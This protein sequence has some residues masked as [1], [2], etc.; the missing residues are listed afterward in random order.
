MK[1]GDHSATI[2][3]PADAN[4]RSASS[5]GKFP[6]VVAPPLPAP[7][8]GGKK[9]LAIFDFIFRICAAVAALAAAAAMSNGQETLPFFTQFFQFQA[10]YNDIPTFINYAIPS[11]RFF[12]VAMAIVGGYLVLS[13]PFSIV[14]ILRPRAIGPRFLLL[15]LDLI[16]FSLTTAA[17]AAAADILYLAHKGNSNANWLAICQQFGNFCQNASGAVVGSFIAAALL[18][19]MVVLA[20]T[21]I[22]RA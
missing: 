5:K 6:P 9:V 2:D 21:A 12:T 11:C 1:N 14:C 3:V 20:A 22:R 7:A 8:A 18:L 16:A 4:G 15:I 10:Q 19:I 17:G 13:L